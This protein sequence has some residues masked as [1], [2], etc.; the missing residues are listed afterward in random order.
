MSDLAASKID[1]IA[2]QTVHFLRDRVEAAG[3]HIG[4]GSVIANV[5]YC[6][7]QAMCAIGEGETKEQAKAGAHECLDMLYDQQYDM[8]AAQVAALVKAEG[9][10]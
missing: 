7:L 1:E 2:N 8:A 3:G 4:D 6:S 9:V 10:S 5:V